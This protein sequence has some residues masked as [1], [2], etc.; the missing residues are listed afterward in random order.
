MARASYP[1]DRDGVAPAAVAPRASHGDARGLRDTSALPSHAR[2]TRAEPSTPSGP[3]SAKPTRSSRPSSAVTPTRSA[4]RRERADVS[5]GGPSNTPRIAPPAS[6]RR[7]EQ[8][9][10]SKD[11]AEGDGAEHRESDTSGPR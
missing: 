3:S 8:W 7:S 1:A 4:T 5:C 11:L 6:R 9:N 2:Q 10:I